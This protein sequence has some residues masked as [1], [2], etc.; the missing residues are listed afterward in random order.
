MQ[1]SPAMASACK[2]VNSSRSLKFG[3]IFIETSLGIS[4]K[5]KHPDRPQ[6]A[7][8]VMDTPGH[9]TSYTLL[10]VY[11]DS[12]QFPPPVDEHFDFA[13]ISTSEQASPLAV[14]GG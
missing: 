8:C 1:S 11:P 13:S 2:Q 10:S 14:V 4:T 7:L 6:E 3:Q 5:S 9:L 12:D